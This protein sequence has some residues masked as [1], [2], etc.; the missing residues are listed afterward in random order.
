MEFS[1]HR[2]WE[3]LQTP[4]AVDS[5]ANNF[6]HCD[7]PIT[8]YAIKFFCSVEMKLKAICAF[9]ALIIKRV[10]KYFLKFFYEQCHRNPGPPDCNIHCF[11]ALSA[12]ICSDK[13]GGFDFK[14]HTPLNSTADVMLVATTVLEIRALSKTMKKQTVLQTCYHTAASHRV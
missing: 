5:F 6:G 12:L 4:L 1:S 9:I 8:A 13:K 3:W 2:S 7:K 14:A 10:V 11:I